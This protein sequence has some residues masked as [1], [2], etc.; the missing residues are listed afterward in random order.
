M[1]AGSPLSYVCSLHEKLLLSY[2]FSLYSR[3]KLSTPNASRIEV[4]GSA[5]GNVAVDIRNMLQV[6][7]PAALQ[8]QHKAMGQVKARFEVMAMVERRPVPHLT[9]GVGTSS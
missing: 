9:L 8:G 7:M 3:F 1:K 6:K 2:A 4:S 5:W